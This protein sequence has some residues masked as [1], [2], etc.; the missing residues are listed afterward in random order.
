[1][2]ATNTYALRRRHVYGAKVFS[3]KGFQTKGL[4]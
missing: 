1:M 4:R 2:M 3:D